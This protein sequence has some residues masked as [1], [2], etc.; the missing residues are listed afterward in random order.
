MIEDSEHTCYVNDK[1]ARQ[2][3]V[4]KISELGG[5]NVYSTDK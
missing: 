2:D 4:T 1:T 5:D 3:P